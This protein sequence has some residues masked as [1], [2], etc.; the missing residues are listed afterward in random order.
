MSDLSAARD[1]IAAAVQTHAPGAEVTGI[2]PLVGGACQDNVRV[3]L[4]IDGEPSRLVVRSDAASGIPGTIDRAREYNVMQAA[5][6]AGV[7]TPGVHWLTEGLLRPGAWAYFMDWSDGVA[8]GRQVLKT[9]ELAGAR[10][11]LAAELAGQAARIHAITP[12]SS[13]G[14]SITALDAPEDSDAIAHGIRLTREMINQLDAPTPA[15]ELIFRW[16]VEN[17][18]PT[19]DVVLSHGDFRIGNFMVTPNGL[20]NVLDWEFARWSSPYDDLAWVSV[21]DWRFNRIHKPIGGF[22][23]RAPFY[24]A[25]EEASGRA[26][27][28]QDVHWWE[29]N[30]NLRWGLGCAFQAQRYAAGQKDL[31]LIAIGRRAAEMEYEALRLIET[32]VAGLG[33]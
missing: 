7:Q 12:E 30:G 17:P 2:K 24:A 4:L 25:Y 10:A 8:I 22:S 20:A 27:N 16:M 1:A 9:P 18:P 21:R 3:D 11:G 6:A 31:E 33:A 14:K 15:T 19:R 13:I 32:G 29:I 28:L 26:V 5:A 23:G